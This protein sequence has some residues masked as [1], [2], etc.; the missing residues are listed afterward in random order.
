MKL[1]RAATRRPRFLALDGAYHG[2]GMGSTSLM[3]P[4]PFRDPVRATLVAGAETLPFGDVDA[5]AR[6]LAARRRRVRR[7]RA[8]PGRRRR[9]PAAGRRTSTAL[10]ELTAR[11]GALLVADEV[12]TGLGRIGAL[13]ALR[14]TWPRRP[15]VRPAGQGPGRRPHADLGDADDARAVRARLRR[16]LR[17]RR[18]AQLHL[19]LQRGRR[20]SPRSRRWSCSPTS[21]FATVSEKGRRVS[22]ARSPSALRGS[23]LL[24]RG[25]RRRADARRRPAPARSPV[26][27]VRALRVRRARGLARRPS[28]GAAGLPPPVPARLLLLRLRPRLV[29]SCACSRGSR[30]RPRPCSASPISCAARPTTCWS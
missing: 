11:H 10:C 23:P 19:Q 25:A 22:R 28:V 17:D 9:A 18:G 13:P 24:S 16:E 30:S 14:E 26:A 15:D 12:Q 7:G 21:C 5:L 1:A 3:T 4:G 29:A 20:P 8:D 6:A 27:V 2:C